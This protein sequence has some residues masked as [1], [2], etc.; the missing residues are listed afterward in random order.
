MNRRR[1]KLPESTVY[2]RSAGQLGVLPS[3][4]VHPLVVFYNFLALNRDDADRWDSERADGTVAP[5]DARAFAD[6][7]FT[8]C[9]WGAQALNELRR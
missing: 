9:Q 1:C 3:E 6:R 7:L 5:G 2:L 4:A 8:L